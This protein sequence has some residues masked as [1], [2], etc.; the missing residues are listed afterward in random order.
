MHCSHDAANRGQFAI[1]IS[2]RFAVLSTYSNQQ[3]NEPSL[4]SYPALPPRNY[5]RKSANNSAKPYLKKSLPRTLINGHPVRQ[6]G[7][8]NLQKLGNEEE[9]QTIPTIVNGVYCIIV[10]ARTFPRWRRANRQSIQLI[11]R[12]WSHCPRCLPDGDKNG[13]LSLRWRQKW[14]SLSFSSLDFLNSCL[15][16]STPFPCLCLVFFLCLF[17]STSLPF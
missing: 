13:G 6:P 8:H 12:D 9:V 16:S 1:P 2:N 15:L 14:R 4:T 17:L 3:L 11:R 7:N 5:S 10:S